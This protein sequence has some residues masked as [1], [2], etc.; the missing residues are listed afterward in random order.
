MAAPTYATDLVDITTAETI[1]NWSALGGGASGLGAGPDFAMQG[2]NCV[3]KQVTASEKGQIYNNGSTITPGTNEHFFLW[4]FLATPGLAATLA[5]RGLGVVL[6]TGTTAYN[7]FHVEG[8]DTYGAQG[9]VGRCYP[10][11]YVNTSSGSVPYRTL[12]GSPGTAPQYF[13]ATTNI[14]GTVK[15]ANLGTDAVRRGTGIYITAGDSGD[16]GTFNGA[17]TQNDSVSNRWGVLTALSAVSFELQGRFAV[18]QNTSGT[19]TAAYFSASNKSIAVVDTP[20]SLTDF[21]QVIV[22]HASTTFNL[23]NCTFVA[24]GTN[25]PGRLVFNNTSTTSA[26]TGCTWDSFGISTLRVGVTATSCTWRSSGLVTQNSATITG[27]KFEATSDATRALDSDD[28]SKLTNCTF[29]S[30]GT[31]HAIRA[32]VAGT[33]AFSGNSFSGYAGSDG[34]T[35]N[36]AFYNDSGGLITLNISGGTT[37][38]VRN[39]SGASTV[40]NST[41]TVTVTPLATGSEVRAYR[42]SDGVEVSGTETSTGSS[43]ALSLPSG[44]AVN[45][46]VLGPVTGSTQYVPVRIENVSFTVSQNLNPGQRIDRNFLNL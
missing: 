27:A 5:N 12:T 21:T 9:R 41:V 29:T 4:V 22:D 33:Y 18:G 1:T 44:T 36:E 39:G 2:T 23:T 7:T 10:I 38:S 13:G 45:I 14:S 26:L 19:P 3:D 32:T 34:S 28:P 6:G 11:R 35:G 31:K 43:Y 8:S 30:G 16:P 24:G 37:P 42:V 40:V 17:A 15:G 46:V 20:H 25:N